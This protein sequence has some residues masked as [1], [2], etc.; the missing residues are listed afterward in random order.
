MGESGLLAFQ[1]RQKDLESR[2]TGVFIAFLLK[3]ASKSE[4]PLE[5][6]TLVSHIRKCLFSGQQGN[7]ASVS[8]VA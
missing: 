4:F 8:G 1:K 2:I 5:L 7:A 6:D 3:S